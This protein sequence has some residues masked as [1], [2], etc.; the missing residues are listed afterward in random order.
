MNKQSISKL[1]GNF[2]KSHAGVLADMAL[3]ENSD[4]ISE[5]AYLAA[6]KLVLDT[7]GISIAGFHADGMKAVIDQMTEW[8]GKR[9]ASLWVSGKKL[10]SPHTVFANSA[11]AHAYDFDQTHQLGVGHIMVS[12]LPVCLALAEMTGCSG[13]DFLA[14]II[15]GQEVT[16]RLGLAFHKAREKGD[17]FALGFLPASVVGGFGTTAAACRLLGMNTEQTIYAMGINY[18]QASG[19]RQALFEKT[20]TKRLQPAFTAR[21]AIWAAL[22]ARRGISG[23]VYSIEGD[24]GLFR[25]Y[26]HT[27]PCS[28]DDLTEKRNFYEVE[29][30]SIKP[31][32]CCGVSNAAVAVEL[33]QKYKFK[34]EDIDLIQVHMHPGP[35][36]TGGKFK[37]G[38]NPQA[39]VQFSSAYTAAL[40]VLR[41]RMG[42]QEIQSEQILKDT[43]TAE[44]AGRVI[45]AP[46][47]ELPP[48]AASDPS[49]LPW[50]TDGNHYS[51]IK[52]RTKDGKI[53]TCFKTNREI[54]GPEATMAMEHVTKKYYACTGFSG[55][56]PQKKAE[57]IFDIIMNLEKCKN[58]AGLIKNLNFKL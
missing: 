50:R 17:Y 9:E 7:I 29:R 13:Q 12:L 35:S 54:L 10:P 46:L 58:V 44:L 28:A 5:S 2:S 33:G 8:G 1:S 51:G 19:N 18:A 31:Y 43:E 6:K 57:Q 55:I 3:S 14:A 26:K 52:V 32:P 24:A 36:L 53:Y 11:M 42:L 34:Y 21:S 37:F 49:L 15:M 30:D 4:E 41:G 38:E 40:G 16:C 20:L 39:S 45:L 47:E 23:P 25:I 27:D 56:C 22:L 48:P